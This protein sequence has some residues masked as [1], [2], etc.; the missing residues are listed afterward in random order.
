MTGTPA[1]RVTKLSK[2]YRVYNRSADLLLE[3]V[4]GRDRHREHWALKD[5]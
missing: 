1:I 2:M 3:M 4:T 5:V